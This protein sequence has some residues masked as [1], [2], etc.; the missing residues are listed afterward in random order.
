MNADP[1]NAKKHVNNQQLKDDKTPPKQY[2]TNNK[3]KK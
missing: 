3:S 1:I 2:L